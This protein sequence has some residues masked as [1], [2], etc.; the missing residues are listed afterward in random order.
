[1]VYGIRNRNTESGLKR[2]FTY[3][4]YRIL[5]LSSEVVIPENAGDFRLLDE[6][7]VEAIKTL[8]EKKK[9]TVI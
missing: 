2:L 5:N 4:Y 1:M 7:V 9:K 8:P 6:K 3:V